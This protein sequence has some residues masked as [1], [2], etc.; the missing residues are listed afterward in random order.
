M[1]SQN[2]N[3]RRLRP[4]VIESVRLRAERE[5]QLADGAL[6]ALDELLSGLPFL[7]RSLEQDARTWSRKVVLH[8]EIQL[9]P[10]VVK[11]LELLA[12]DPTPETIRSA[13]QALADC[14]Q[15]SCNRAEDDRYEG[16]VRLDLYLVCLRET[17]EHD[18]LIG[19]IM[20]RPSYGRRQDHRLAVATFLA[21]AQIRALH[22]DPLSPPLCLARGAALLHEASGWLRDETRAE[23]QADQPEAD[24]VEGVLHQEI[25]EAMLEDRGEIVRDGGNLARLARSGKVTSQTSLP[26]VPAAPAKADAKRWQAFEAIAGKFL[27]LVGRGDVPA[28]KAALEDRFPHLHVAINALAMELAGLAHVRIRPLLLVGSPGSGKTSLARAIGEIT[29]LPSTVYSCAGAAD[30]SLMGTSAQWS[31]A[32]P[33]VPLDLIRTSRVANPLVILDELDKVDPGRHNGSLA[34][35]LLAFL[36]PTSAQRYRDLSLEVEVDLS[37]V[38]WIATAN[39]LEDVPAALR[40]RFKVFR[41]PDPTWTHIGELSRLILDDIARERELD[42][43]W[44][45]DLAPDEIEVVKSGW[46]GGSLRR[47]R[48]AITVIVDGRDRLMVR[49]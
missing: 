32:R 10:N 43:R 19:A 14:D 47:L 11:A 21:F 31:S 39:K 22:A 9:R 29:R 15:L 24:E 33:S 13:R 35:A 34:D 38:N 27:P 36:E 26:V 41:I 25:V 12:G 2:Q 16:L 46:P 49:S 44:L 30:S 17:R 20:T 18:R 5:R 42:R 1:S 4:A 6:P 28:Q 37:R 8:D 48:R 45:E 7:A 3:A 23:E 40:D